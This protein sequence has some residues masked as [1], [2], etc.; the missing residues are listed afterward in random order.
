MF[1][2]FQINILVL[3]LFT[4]LFTNIYICHFRLYNVIAFHLKV[5]RRYIFT[6][7]KIHKVDRFII[8]ISSYE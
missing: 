8:N 4:F 1:F 6:N 3:Q 5:E 7:E 2:K